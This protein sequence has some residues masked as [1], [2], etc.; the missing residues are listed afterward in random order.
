MRKRILP[1]L[2]LI[3]GLTL[4]ACTTLS[5]RECE[6]IDWKQ[7]GAADGSK[8][9]PPGKFVR[10]AQ[11]CR[12]HGLQANEAAYQEGFKLG[13]ENFCTYKGGYEYG[14]A[15]QTDTNY[16][17]KEKEAEF[18]RGNLAGYAVYGKKREVEVM[19]RALEQSLHQCTFDS[20]CPKPLRCV[21]GSSFVGGNYVSYRRCQ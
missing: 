4:V 16:C 20:D 18:L 5:R 12:E 7:R 1:F 11:A 13:L 15:G 10:E 19:S 8:G 6:T 21:Y 2:F 3:A 9:A 14:L 17:S